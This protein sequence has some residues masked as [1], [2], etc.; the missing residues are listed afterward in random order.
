[1][2]SHVAFVCLYM[3]AGSGSG[4]CDVSHPWEEVQAY[5]DSHGCNVLKGGWGFR[6]GWLDLWNWSM[7]LWGFMMVEE[8]F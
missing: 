4:L 1:M 2:G 8:H 7:I 3:R 5:A 6:G